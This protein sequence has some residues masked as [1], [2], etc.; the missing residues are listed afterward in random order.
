MTKNQ[1]ITA[2]AAAARRIETDWGSLSWLAG[3]DVGNCPELTLGRVVIRRGRSNPRHCHRSCAEVLHLL[4][5]KLEHSIGA[6]MV[7]LSPG[8]TLTIPPGIFHDAASIGDEDAEM[9]VAYP[10]G[11]RDF[12]AEG[13]D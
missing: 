7:V 9:I 1:V 13:A 4:R 5:G 8:D 10:T 12:V 6:G 3:S 2:D 11:C